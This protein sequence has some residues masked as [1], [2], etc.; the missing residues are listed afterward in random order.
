[1]D[2]IAKEYN[3]AFEDLLIKYMI[4][5]PDLYIRSQ[6][7]I[8]SDYFNTKINKEIIDLFEKHSETY[9]CLP[10]PEQ[11]EAL[12]GK[13]IEPFAALADNQK[14][15][16]FDEIEM[17]CRHKAIELA[18]YESTFLLEKSNY[19]EMEKRVKEAVQIGLVKDLGVD[20]FSDPKGRL[21][22]MLEDKK[23]VP[24]GW[25][26]V[27]N[28]LYGG[29]EPGTLSVVCGQSGAGKSIVL[30]NLAVTWASKGYN[31]LYVSLELSE[32]LC[33]LRL[34]A[35]FTDSSTRTL[36][37]DIEDTTI[38]LK[39]IHKKS[40]GDVRIK[41]MKNGTTA[42]DLRAY[43]RELEIQTNK[44]IQVVLLDYLDLFMPTTKGIS[45]SD[46][47]TKDKYVS[48]ELR[49]VA[50][51]LSVPFFTASQLNRGSH[52]EVEFGHKDIAGGMSKINTADNVLAIYVTPHMKEQGRFQLQFL[53]TRSSSGVGKK[54]DLT[55]NTAT[56]RLTDLDE[57]DVGA[58]STAASLMGNLKAKSTVL[59][60]EPPPSTT[61]PLDKLLKSNS[62]RK[63]LQK[64]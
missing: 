49:N 5:D 58:T 41:Q 23:A 42:N 38:K 7:I 27:D 8:K 45:M 62:L 19:G 37:K 52:E 54:V 57:A 43:I 29:V 21:A 64:D 32:E 55:F 1:M 30:Q 44:K 47:F 51:E 33:A 39:N 11:V 22:K 53:K 48:E 31:V 14:T 12:L 17:F 59:P 50:V 26:E 24:T 18:I 46:V 60:K 56:M 10:T 3:S 16:Y 9:S 25:T 36:V 13:K 35:M 2:S 15:F 20:Y 63:M 61:D 4:S 6:S 40:K 28:I 34:D